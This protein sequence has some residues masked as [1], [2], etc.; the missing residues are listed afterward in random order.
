[1][2][3][4]NDASGRTYTMHGVT[5]TSHA[6]S[7]TGAAQLAGWCADFEPHSPGQPHRMSHEELLHV[8]TGTLTV[9][10]DGQRFEAGTGDTV[11]IPAGAS[12][13][14]NNLSDQPARAWVVTTLGMTATMDA[15]GSPIT[16][17]WAQ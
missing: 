7:A 14:A 4:L 3:V 12:F 15:D 9:D 5:F 1:M 17:P 8:L 13:C 16:P 10:I 2:T 6:S 11:L